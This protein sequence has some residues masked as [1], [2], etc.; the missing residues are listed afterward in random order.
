MGTSSDMNETVCTYFCKDR[1][2]ERTL[3]GVWS[4]YLSNDRV[5]LGAI[6]LCNTYYTDMASL[7][8]LY[9]SLI[10]ASIVCRVLR[11][12]GRYSL[13]YC[14]G[15]GKRGRREKKEG[16]YIS[17]LAYGTYVHGV[18]SA[19]VLYTVCNR[20]LVQSIF[21]PT[22]SFVL[23]YTRAEPLVSPPQLPHPLPTNN[24]PS[25]AFTTPPRPRRCAVAAAQY[26]VPPPPPP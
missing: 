5:A 23:P 1:V 9:W 7:Y 14:I 10:T 6:E 19:P 2:V 12:V 24:T 17:F 25:Q 11:A 13:L 4:D 21:A 26:S 20:S 18:C 15:F 22:H 16:Q 8:I 3:S